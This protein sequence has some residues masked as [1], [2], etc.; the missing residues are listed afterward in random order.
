MG[1]G[2]L[3]GD[4]DIFRQLNKF[5]SPLEHEGYFERRL[6]FRDGWVLNGP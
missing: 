3:F 2:A 4:G 5:K 1:N 6:T